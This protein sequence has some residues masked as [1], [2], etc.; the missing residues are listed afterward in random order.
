MC[1]LTLRVLDSLPKELSERI[2]CLSW[3]IPYVRIAALSS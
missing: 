3:P 2:L 1:R